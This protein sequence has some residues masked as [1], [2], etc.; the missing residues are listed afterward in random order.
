[1][2]QIFIKEKLKQMGINLED[3]SLGDFDQIGEFTAKKNRSIS[4]VFYK[5]SGCFFRPNYERGILMYYL[6]RKLE[7]ESVLEIGFGRGYSAFCMAKAMCDHGIDGKITT[8]DPNFNEEFLKYLSQIFP[9]IWFDKIDFVSA[10]SDEYFAKNP[11]KQYDFIY[12]DGDHTFQ[13]VKND[14]ENT[15]NKFKKALLFD[16]YHMPTKDSGPGIQCAKLIDTIDDDSKELIIM[17]RRIFTDDRGL[18]DSEIDY[19]QVLLTIKARV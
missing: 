16:D 10:T 14:W 2:K 11:D 12:I 5:N 13:A 19:G 7:F 1:M 18:Q 15:K 17:D 8:V 9:K 6:T 4:N 3:M